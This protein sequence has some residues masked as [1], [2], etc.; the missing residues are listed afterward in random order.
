MSD[1]RKKRLRGKLSVVIPAFAQ[2]T[3]I[4]ADLVRVQEKIEEISDEYEILVVVDGDVDKTAERARAVAGPRT[5][6]D[7]IHENRGKGY[8]VRHGVAQ[9]DGSIVGFIDAGGDIDAAGIETA[10]ALVDSGVADLA[11]GSK[12][13]PRSHV[14]Y[15]LARRVYSRGYQLLC[16]ILFN[17]NVRDTQVGIKFMTRE[18]A[19]RVFPA[20]RTDGFAFDIELL[21]LAQRRGF[22]RIE[23]CPVAVDLRFPS[24]IGTGTVF[25]MLWD[26]L[27]VFYRMR[28]IKSY[29]DPPELP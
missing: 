10:A 17:L 20:L 2:E 13:H 28:I 19:D 29:D 18:V 22:T 4:G 12:R 25:D 3:A 16:R 14:E 8:A 15:P 5:R 21:A 27:R 26:A 7:V 1:P 23:E 6:I 9:T 11:V 24:T